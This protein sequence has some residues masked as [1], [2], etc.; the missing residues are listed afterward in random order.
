MSENTKNRILEKSI[1]L[2]NQHG[3]ENVSMRDI[4][5]SLKISPGNLTY[6]FKKKTDIL[7]EILNCL[8]H[9]HEQMQYKPEITLAEFNSI[10]LLTTQHQKHYAFYYR[11]FMEL[12]HKYPEIAQLQKDYKEEF[13]VL[14]RGIFTHF[15]K[16]EWMKPEVSESM[17]DNLS[18]AVLSIAI[19]WIQFGIDRDMRSVIWSILL[20]NLTEKGINDYQKIDMCLDY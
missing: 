12:K 19:F 10:L 2:F 3:F 13:L 11:N 16:N 7:D 5:E 15:E 14:I 4:S 8:K 9:D 20:P 6:H 18:Y 17:Y 1:E